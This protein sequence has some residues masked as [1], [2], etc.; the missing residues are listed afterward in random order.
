MHRA[1]AYRH[2]TSVPKKTERARPD[3]VREGLVVRRLRN[4]K[5]V[6]AGWEAR[7]STMRD[8]CTSF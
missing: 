3:R 5:F 6:A 7:A 1:L 8:A 2:L 4:W